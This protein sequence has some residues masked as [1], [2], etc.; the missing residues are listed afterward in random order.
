MPTAQIAFNLSLHIGPGKFS[1]WYPVSAQNWWM[2]IFD[3]HPTLV[4]PCVIVHKRMSL[5]HLSL[6]LQLCP[7]YSVHLAWI[8]WEMWPYIWVFFGGG[9]NFQNLFKTAY[10]ILVYFPSSFFLPSISL[11]FKLC[12]YTV[13]LT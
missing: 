12:N 1:R 13:V 2:Y 9:C 10:S 6:V 7:A 5:M 3:G 4:C 11:K 8:V